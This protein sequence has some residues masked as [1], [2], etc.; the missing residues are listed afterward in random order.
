MEEIVTETGKHYQCNLV[1]WE[2]VVV[3][4]CDHETR[5]LL[6][7]KELAEIDL[8]Q[9]FSLLEQSNCAANTGRSITE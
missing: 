9:D 1:T 3:E 2:D 7:D 5:T 8:F 6:R 4:D